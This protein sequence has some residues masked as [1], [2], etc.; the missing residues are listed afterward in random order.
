MSNKRQGKN[1]KFAKTKCLGN[2]RYAE[3]V[4]EVLVLHVAKVV[5]LPPIGMLIE[6]ALRSHSSQYFGIQN[7]DFLF[8][9]MMVNACRSYKF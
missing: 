2:E 4:G 9:S 6:D 5:L 3:C 7:M 8:L 1:P